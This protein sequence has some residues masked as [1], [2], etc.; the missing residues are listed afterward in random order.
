MDFLTRLAETFLDWKQIAEVLPS[1]LAVGLPNTLVLA[2]TSGLIGAFLGLVLALMGISR[3]PLA[4]W[5]ARVYTDVFRGLPAVLTIL[6]IGLGFGPIF[7]EITGS[8]SPYPMGIAALSLMAAAY[9]GEIF[10]SGIQSVD[11]GQLEA[12]RALGFG[13]GPSMRSIVVPQGIRRVLPALMN[14]FIALIKDSSLVFTLGLLATERELFQIGQDA[15]ARSG[16]LSP[17]VAAAI[18]YLAMT[19]PLTHLVNYI[20]NRLRSGRPQKLEPD[21]AAAVVGK[22]AQA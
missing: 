11:K 14:Q 9:T 1:M 15:A 16:N 18:F 8:N 21:E 12:A 5:A 10:R 17:Y 20:D 2:I 22:G 3:N 7:R 6:V 13:Y 19:I 4:R